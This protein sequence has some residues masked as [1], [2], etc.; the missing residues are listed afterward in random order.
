MSPVINGLTAWLNS[1]A[2][3]VELAPYEINLLLLLLLSN[4]P[5]REYARYTYCLGQ[6][7]LSVC[8]HV[9]C[10]DLYCYC[11]YQ[12]IPDNIFDLILNI[13]KS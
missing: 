3:D 11:L 9:I 1:G 8:K 7:Q 4:S 6:K 2:F 10:L 13:A 12:I 5:R